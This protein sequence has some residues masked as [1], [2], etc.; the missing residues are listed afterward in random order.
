[1]LDSNRDAPGWFERVFHLE[2]GG[3]HLN[4]AEDHRREDEAGYP[5][6]SLPE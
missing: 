1:V 2:L 3:L 6:E 5:K 4:E